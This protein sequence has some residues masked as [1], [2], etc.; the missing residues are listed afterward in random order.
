MTC[1]QHAM[2][3]Q[4]R[5][6]PCTWQT[7]S[8][9]TSTFP[10]VHHPPI[11]LRIFAPVLIASS[12]FQSFAT[13]VQQMFDVNLTTF[14]NTLFGCCRGFPQRLD[15][16][17]TKTRRP[18]PSRITAATAQLLRSSEGFLGES[19]SSCLFVS[20]TGP[21]VIMSLVSAPAISSGIVASG[22]PSRCRFA[23]MSLSSSIY[24]KWP[25]HLGPS[26]VVHDSFHLL[27]LC[28]SVLF[29]G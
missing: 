23:S 27:S 17:D 20:R 25:R 4:T 21:S 13:S 8:R 28:S 5:M 11:F 22:S 6:D 10:C 3:L 7:L 18:H 1:C 29:L 12:R 9:T 19:F 14:H 2:P 26:S 24:R 15:T 16:A